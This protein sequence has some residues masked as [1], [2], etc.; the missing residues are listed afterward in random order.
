M[1]AS[2]HALLI[3]AANRKLCMAVVT[4]HQQLSFFPTSATWG[5]CW[6]QDS[7]VIN[8]AKQTLPVVV[9]QSHRLPVVT[10]WHLHEKTIENPCIRYSVQQICW[11]NVMNF[12]LGK[13]FS[14]SVVANRTG[15]SLAKLL[16]W[17]SPSHQSERN[18]V[19]AT[20]GLI[21]PGSRETTVSLHLFASCCRIG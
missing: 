17:T 18:F 16:G 7:S 1:L 10:G 2:H 12:Q 3:L 21:W 8:I 20:V 4:Q 14:L 5:V 15:S 11:I 13:M 9:S 19:I 6:A